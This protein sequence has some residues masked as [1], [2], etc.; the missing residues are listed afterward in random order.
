MNRGSSSVTVIVVVILVV[1]CCCL[2][3]AMFCFGGIAWVCFQLNRMAVFPS[4]DLDT[5]TPIVIRPTALP[6]NQIQG[7]LDP[8]PDLSDQLSSIHYL[9]KMMKYHLLRK[10][11]HDQNDTLE[12]LENTIVPIND[13]LDL[14]QRLEG[15]ENIPSNCR[16]TIGALS[17][18]GYRNLLG[19]QCGHQ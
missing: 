4:S 18:W 2:C 16:C 10:I 9:L 11:T 3:L 7:I 17:S 6:D 14:A 13:L 8:L 5:P 19:Y 12:T 15:K 1:L